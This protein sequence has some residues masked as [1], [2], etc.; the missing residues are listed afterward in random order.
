M[1]YKTLHYLGVLVLIS[2]LM[3]CKQYSV[4]LNNNVVYSPIPLF[5]D[6][7][8]A[9][10]HL[11]TCVEQTINDKR[12]TKAEDITQLNCSNAGISNLAGIETFYAIEQLNLEEN[13]LGSV[14]P[15]AALGRL[16][17]LNLRKN[18]LTNAEPLLHLL[19]LRTLDISDNK[20][21][22]CGDIQQ[23]LANFHAGAGHVRQELNSPLKSPLIHATLQGFC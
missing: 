9:D 16:K 1:Q 13:A 20:N 17:V 23:V 18:N 11:R 12:A 21:L 7:T 10:S 2:P 8:I 5:K 4:S 22:A 6:F 19:H 15:L 14:S 3:S